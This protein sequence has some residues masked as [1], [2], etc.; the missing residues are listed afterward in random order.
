MIVSGA[1]TLQ[2]KS[3]TLYQ[4]LLAAKHNSEIS[5]KKFELFKFNH[6]ILI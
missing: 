6:I 3:P 1:F 4:D 2:S 5:N